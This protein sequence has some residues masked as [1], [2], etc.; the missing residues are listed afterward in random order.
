MNI[1]LYN[2]I[3]NLLSDSLTSPN[4]IYNVSGCIQDTLS[5][6]ALGLAAECARETRFLAYNLLGLWQ[7]PAAHIFPVSTLC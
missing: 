5:S 1:Y 4:Y 3:L 7:A 2:S 6:R